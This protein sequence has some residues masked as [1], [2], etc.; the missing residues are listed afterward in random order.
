MRVEIFAKDTSSVLSQVRSLV[1]HGA[2]G[3]N[4][5]HKTKSE[6]PLAVLRAL[7]SIGLPS[8]VLSDV[9]PHYSLKNAPGGSSAEASLAAFESFCEGAAA[10]PVP[11]RQLLLVSGSGSRSFDA[12]KCLRAM[13]LSA[14]RMPEIGVAFNPYFPARP[15]REKEKARLRLK[16]G[17]GRVAAVWLQIGSDVELLREGLQFVRSLATEQAPPL[18]IYGSVFVPSKPLLERMRARPWTGVHLDA[19]YLSSV[20]AAERVTRTVLALYAEHGVQPFCETPLRSKADF[21]HAS[22]LLLCTSD[23]SGPWSSSSV[24]PPVASTPS[25]SAALEPPAVSSPPPSALPQPGQT[26]APSTAVT[27]P[28]KR[29]RSSGPPA[30]TTS[31]GAC[32]AADP[33]GTAVDPAATPPAPSVTVF[34]TTAPTVLQPPLPAAAAA[35]ASAAASSSTT[36]GTAATIVWYRPFDLRTSDHAPLLA[37]AEGG[38]P[39]VPAFV[40]ARQ[41]GRWAPGGA[42]QAWLRA[43]LSSLDEDLRGLG[44]QLVL[45]CAGDDGG[46]DGSG[47]EVDLPAAVVDADVAAEA[48]DT[49]RALVAL[50]AECG[51]ARVVWHRSYDGPDAQ[52]VDAAVEAALRAAGVATAPLAGYLLY[53]P[54]AV[55]LPGGFAGGHWGTLMPFLKACERQGPHVPLPRPAPPPGTLVAPASWPA[56]APLEALRLAA[57]PVR[58]DGSVGHDWGGG[59]LSHWR[60][61]EAAAHEA[62]EAFVD[63]AGLVGYESKRSR[64]DEPSAV[65]TLSAHIRWGQL[66]ARQLYHAVRRRGLPR[67]ATKTFSRR[68]HW[69]DL[70]YFQLAHFPRMTHFPIRAHYADH[71]WSDEAEAR[72]DA[73]R[74]GATG[75][76]MVDSGMRQLYA[77]GWMHQ[78][79][80]M[81]CASFLVEH[82]GVSWVEGA[83]WFHHTL[84]D[85]DVAINSMMWQNAGRSG[86]DQW[87]FVLSPEAGSQDSSGR[88]CRRWLPELA[89]LP[90]KHLHA[91]WGAPESTLREAEVVIGVTYPHR[92]VADL[93]AARAQT[94]T[95]LRACRAAHLEHNDAGGY[96]LITLPSGERT[97]VFTKQEFRLDAAGR[98]KPIDPARSGGG[99][100][101]GRGGG[102]GGGA[103]G[104]GAGARGGGRGAAGRGGRERGGEDRS[105]REFFGSK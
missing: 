9:V 75:Y 91:P 2:R 12:V 33:A 85:A 61:G 100:A 27:R 28:A 45:R 15:D 8:E 69:R 25:Q 34:A 98:P 35:A 65:S 30:P 19:T 89:R 14:D 76:P 84:V 70:A 43:A 93:A 56:S 4:L 58:A 22:R 44:S 26:L 10:L 102:R 96:D 97:R 101:G 11:P 29:A 74:R 53:E 1:G 87:N 51:A 94:V 86:I 64:A 7:Q 41:R 88:L 68:L 77:T 57:P 3:L 79:V 50:A 39:C 80:R 72:L 92:I 21:D 71:A 23:P 42:A 20:D 36:T 52:L 63:G 59:L 47:S 104:G 90:T 18:R 40:W 67:D 55:A 66:S 60:V 99:R 6:Q 54:Q 95:A 78:S 62:M 49:A 105:I 81:V 38:T 103:R 16:L 24:V 5:P 17:S 46:A 31:D 32:G 73:W 82:L 37:A 48:R 83:R 13:R